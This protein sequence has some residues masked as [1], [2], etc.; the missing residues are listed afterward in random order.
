MQRADFDSENALLAKREAD[1]LLRL[2]KDMI[3]RVNIAASEFRAAS[4]AQVHF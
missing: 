3:R 2:K 1:D 4:D